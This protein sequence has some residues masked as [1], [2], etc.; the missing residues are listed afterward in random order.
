MSCR[1]SDPIAARRALSAIAV[2]AALVAVAGTIAFAAPASAA[3]TAPAIPFPTAVCTS[4]S[5]ATAGASAPGRRTTNT[6]KPGPAASTG[7]RRTP[8]RSAAATATPPAT[9]A[10]TPTPTPT[11]QAI[12]AA[13]TAANSPAP[14]PTPSASSTGAGSWGWL[15]G[16]W[17]WIFG[18]V[19]LPHALAAPAP[20]A[21][22]ARA[23]VATKPQSTATSAAP[24]GTA[25]CLPGSAL[26]KAATAATADV[27]AADIP[28]HLSS[29]SMTMY[30]LTYNG[31]V[32][33]RT[34]N[35]PVRALDF[36]ASKITL[37]SMVTSSQQGDG[38]I[39]YNNG[40]AGKTVTLINT[41]LWT[42]TLKGN[43][44]GLLPVTYTPDSP[45][46]LIPGFPTPI[47]LL[48]TQVEADNAMLNTA[49][50]DIPGFDGHGN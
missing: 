42:T 36:T 9:A 31:I 12:T 27:L 43:L 37:L 10:A 2:P 19:R 11:Q 25:T 44:L 30:N 35:G 34:Q 1:G 17:T 47:P 49:T 7:A 23:A 20:G 13:T 14:S 38:K 4:A 5:T 18:A 16:V 46:P 50:I 3:G 22:F 6:A 26:K 32:T 21:G 24:S 8:S 45:P 40:G 29:P 15:N 33:V 28:W 39:Q 48:F 41:H